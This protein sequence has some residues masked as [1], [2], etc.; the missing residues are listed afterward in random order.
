MLS[1]KCIYMIIP[2]VVKS[3]F[4]DKY[5]SVEIKLGLFIDQQKVISDEIKHKYQQINKTGNLEEN[6]QVV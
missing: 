2:F 4:L 5:L 3:L 1:Y 6:W